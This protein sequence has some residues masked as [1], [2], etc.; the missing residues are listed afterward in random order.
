VIATETV[1]LVDDHD[2]MRGLVEMLL[3]GYGYTVLAAANGAEALERSA[4]QAGPIDLLVTD[5][6]MPGMSGRELAEAMAARHPGIRVLY[7]S[8][9]LLGAFLD[10]PLGGHEGYLRKPFRSAEL[11]TAVRE[12]LDRPDPGAG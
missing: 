2:Q 8:G 3:S 7:T 12:L 6:S 11:E 9:H 4:A 5:I 10:G 1:L